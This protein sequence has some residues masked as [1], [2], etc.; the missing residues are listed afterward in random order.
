MECKNSH[1]S[2]AMRT[3]FPPAP[4]SQD[5][6]IERRKRNSSKLHCRYSLL[7]INEY[8]IKTNPKS[9]IKSLKEL[10]VLNFE[11]SNILIFRIKKMTSIIFELSY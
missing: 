9:R 7:H 6:H 5:Y 2:I 8:L 11:I 3:S 4:I 1:E 10:F